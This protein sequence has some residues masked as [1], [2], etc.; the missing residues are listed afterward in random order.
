MVYHHAHHSGHCL[1]HGRSITTPRVMQ[2]LVTT[3]GP[4][5]HRGN[6]PLIRVYICAHTIVFLLLFMRHTYLQKGI[7]D[8]HK[9]LQIIVTCPRPIVIS[10]CTTQKNKSSNINLNHP[11]Q[12]HGNMFSSQKHRQ[13][14]KLTKIWIITIPLTFTSLC[15]QGPFN[16]V[17]SCVIKCLNFEILK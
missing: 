11:G 13:L 17:T 12:L 10:N 2:T 1:L 16:Y 6:L 14:Y 7:C 8:F 3:L 5:I 9:K 4:W 15:I